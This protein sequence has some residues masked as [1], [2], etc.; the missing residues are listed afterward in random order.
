MHQIIHGKRIVCYTLG[1]DLLDLIFPKRCVSCRKF[2][3]FLCSMCFAY[4][5]FDVETVCIACNKAA[6]DGITHPGC[7]QK[8]TLEGVLASVV[9]EGTMKKLLHAYKF[10]PFVKQVEPI[11][12]SLLYE[13]II[14]KELFHKLLKKNPLLVPI[15]L[16]ALKLR[17]RGYNQ[18]EIL[19]RALGQKF[20]LRVAD[21]LKRNK[22]TVSQFALDRKARRENISGAFMIKPEKGKFLKGQTIILIDDVLTT[23]ATLA[24]AGEMLK[25]QGA[26]EVWGVT[27][28]HGR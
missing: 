19:A 18:A 20:N 3:S 24:E 1:M 25:K 26:K 28:A 9:Y 11:L 23:G 4:I 15:P 2:G 7:R 6:I 22:A 13:G 21:L 14:Q 17:Q 16:H 27:L 5:S 10:A 8:N 12:I